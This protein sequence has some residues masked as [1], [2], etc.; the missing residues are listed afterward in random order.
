M[1]SS[2]T[3][4]G[5]CRPVPR[6]HRF[7]Y[8]YKETLAL[9]SEAGLRFLKVVQETVPLIVQD[10]FSKACFVGLAYALGSAGIRAEIAGAHCREDTNDV[11]VDARSSA[12][13]Y[14]RVGQKYVCREL[15]SQDARRNYELDLLEEI[16]GKQ[17]AKLCVVVS[18]DSTD[19]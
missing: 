14:V 15:S 7:S 3:K 8:S 6:P 1:T 13:S 12:W 5:R 16:K 9:L 10:G 17:L 19:R 4:Y 11:R 18:P 2:Y